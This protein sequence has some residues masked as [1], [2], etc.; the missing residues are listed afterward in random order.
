MFQKYFFNF[1]SWVFKAQRFFKARLAKTRQKRRGNPLKKLKLIIKN[2]FL[3]RI[4]KKQKQNITISLA[5][6]T[7]S[8]PNSVI[9]LH[10]TVYPPVQHPPG[11][12]PHNGFQLTHTLT[13]TTSS[14]P[15]LPNTHIHNCFSLFNN[16]FYFYFRGCMAGWVRR[17]ERWMIG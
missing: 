7:R 8:F 1:Y 6:R 11:V 16:I 12:R 4:K 15:I 14:H 13:H 17:G 10:P 3:V 9:S 5:V 2:D